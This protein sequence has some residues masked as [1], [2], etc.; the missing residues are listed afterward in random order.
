MLQIFFITFCTFF[1][2]LDP[3]PGYQPIRTPGRKLT[4]TPTP[5]GGSGFYLQVSFLILIRDSN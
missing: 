1:Q 4:A 2:V 5:A 3:P